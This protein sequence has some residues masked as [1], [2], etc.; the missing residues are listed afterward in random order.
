MR[1]KISR[2]A[3]DKIKAPRTG[4]T[5]IWDSEL[6][7]FG[8]RITAANSRAY[9]VQQRVG[10]KERRVTIAKLDVMAPDKARTEAKKVLGQ[11]ASGID[12]LAERARAK[13][14]AVTLATAFAAFKV[15]RRQLK[16]L[17]VRDM[18][19]AFASLA[20]DKKRIASI[21]PDM[22]LKRHAELGKASQARANLTMRYL[23]AV[24]NF[25]AETYDDADGRP[26]LATNPVRR[27]SKVRAWY[28]VERR[29]TVIKEHELKAW[30]DAILA[31]HN[32]DARDYFLVILLTGLRRTEAFDLRWQD[33]DLKAKTFT[34]PDPKNRRPHMLPLSDYLLNI[35][36]RRHAAATSDDASEA[37]REYVFASDRGR[38]HNLRFAMAEVEKVSGVRFCIHDLR[39]TFATAAERLDI[40]AYALK[41][42]MNHKGNGDV[43]EGYIGLDVERLHAPMQRITDYMLAAAGVRASA[44]VV[45]FPS[46]AGRSKT[47][48]NKLQ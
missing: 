45:P 6:R 48:A 11:F 35:F 27:L 5:L 1:T 22:V 17:T 18:E 3:I 16:P 8:V 44:D 33:V 25:A 26:I 23:R 10:G 21:T 37:A 40:S 28:A 42:L 29:R 19:R 34:I 13:A 43:T 36:M 20:W 7:N 47:V 46:N 9:F 30:T 38:L 14:Q 31:L 39:R 2:T 15:A 24:L 32:V 12:P 41:R 4:Y